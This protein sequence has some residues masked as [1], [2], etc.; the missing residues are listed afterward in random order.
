[1]PAHALLPT[2]DDACFDSLFLTR[3][4]SSKCRKFFMKDIACLSFSVLVPLTSRVSSGMTLS[5]IPSVRVNRNDGNAD[6]PSL[7]LP[8]SPP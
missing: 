8:T 6:D 3:M 7:S 2:V 4:E 1:M 5:R